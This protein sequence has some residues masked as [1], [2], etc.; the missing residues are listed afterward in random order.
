MTYTYDG[1]GKRVAKSNGQLYWY[2]S[3]ALGAGGMSGLDALVETD[4]AGNTPTEYVF[5]NGRRIARRDPSGSV[6]YY[7][8]NHL[9]STSVITN[10]AGSVVEESDYYPFGGERIV[11][12]NDPNPYKFTGKERDTETGLDYFVARYYSSGYGRFLQA[13][14]P[15]A[16][17]HIS[18][19][20]SWNLYAYVRGNPLA[21]VDPSGRACSVFL[22]NSSSPFCRRAG[23]YGKLDRKLHAK[24][25]FFAAATAVSLYGANTDSPL[26][27]FVVSST[28]RD[29]LSKLGEDLEKVNSGIVESI[30]DGSLS[31]EDL[32][33]QI[34]HMEQTAVQE[35]LDDLKKTNPEEYERL[36]SDANKALNPSEA[37][38][39]VAKRFPSDTA[40]IQILDQLRR[41]LGRD[42]DFANQSDREALGNK[43]IEHVRKTRG[44]D[45]TDKRAAGC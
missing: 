43:L 38:R 35:A 7:F 14:L 33:T 42:I 28:T 8:S 5:F 24:T 1:D 9:G 11:L 36:I 6:F 40:F 16:D 19:P 2:P 13:D 27:A 3:T 25:R 41:D 34:V 12:N 21:Y 4:S 37:M 10:S 26:T 44:C 22:L 20:Q 45:L 18:E 17:Q 32:D 15:F 39:A 23:S 30:Q 29:F 31:G